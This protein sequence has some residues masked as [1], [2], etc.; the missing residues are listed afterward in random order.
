MHINMS[1]P[2][3]IQWNWD[4][5]GIV[6]ILVLLAGF[7]ICDQLVAL[8]HLHEQDHATRSPARYR[9]AFLLGIAVLCVTLISPLAALAHMLFAIHMLQHLLLAF[10]AAPLLVL[11]LSSGIMRMFLRWR[12]FAAAWKWLSMPLIASILFNGNLWLW[13]APPLID[14]ML[15]NSSL[16]LLVQVLYLLTGVLFW[17][18]LFGDPAPTVFPL[19]L[20]GKLV[21]ILL[22]DMP[23]VLLGAGLTFMPPFYPI[24]GPMTRALGIS[25]ALDQ[26][27][28]GLIMWVPGGIFLIVVASILFLQWMLSLEARQ[29]A[30]DERLAAELEE[31]ADDLLESN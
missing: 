23:M 25:P 2:W 16:H 11:G 13:H 20:A 22:S 15:L 21:Y 8:Q 10:A 14:A 12:P 17:W 24:Y 28:A 7:F 18:P 1:Q 4:P 19:N 9:V 3:Y 5:L 31:E 27:L 26:Q 29:K 30:E 6:V